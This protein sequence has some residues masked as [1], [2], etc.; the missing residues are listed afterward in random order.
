MNEDLDFLGPLL[1]GIGAFPFMPGK[2]QRY[3]QDVQK[4]RGLEGSAFPTWHGTNTS[5]EGLPSLMKDREVDINLP[6]TYS[7]FNPRAS[8]SIMQEGAKRHGSDPR[9]MEQITDYDNIGYADWEDG[10]RSSIYKKAI[11]EGLSGLVLDPSIGQFPQS[12]DQNLGVRWYRGALE[13]RDNFFNWADNSG[14][15]RPLNF[16]NFYGR[17]DA[18]GEEEL[19]ERMQELAGQEMFNPQ[20]VLWDP[21][22][23]RQLGQV[24]RPSQTAMNLKEDLSKLDKEHRELYNLRHQYKYTPEWLNK[25]YDALMKKLD[26]LIGLGY[27]DRLG[28]LTHKAFDLDRPSITTGNP[29]DDW[30]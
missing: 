29:A 14:M 15:S 27:F 23:E 18:P 2:L 12:L 6:T 16:Q 26:D 4:I 17:K 11:D 8:T 3:M 30:K 25:D 28:R 24:I 10:Q 21:N 7:G 9:I 1:A 13:N 22:V 5:Y 19:V 20:L